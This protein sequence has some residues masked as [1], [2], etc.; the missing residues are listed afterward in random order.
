M[1]G[2]RRPGRRMLPGRRRGS[3]IPQPWHDERAGGNR[4]TGRTE[5]P[6]TGLTATS[7]PSCSALGAGSPG[8]RGRTIGSSTHS[9]DG[10]RAEGGSRDGR[11][12]GWRGVPPGSD[13]VGV[14]EFVDA[15]PR[16]RRS[17]AE[18][19][20]LAI[21]LGVMLA[22]NAVLLRPLDG[23]AALMERVRP[24]T[25][26]APRRARHADVAN[27]HPH[28]QRHAR[29]ARYRMRPQ[30][31]CAPRRPQISPRR[32]R[33][34]IANI[35]SVPHRRPPRLGQPPPRDRIADPR[36]HRRAVPRRGH[37][38]RVFRIWVSDLISA[39][40]VGVQGGVHR[41]ARRT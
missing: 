16:R 35:T 11:W 25:G 12:A 13:A 33:V 26:G 22:V 31:P 1:T 24:A 21:G 7:R 37:R 19:A 41:W 20:V 5:S 4:R 6:T 8:S 28:V 15:T 30:Q 23:L 10:C 39:R 27:L 18:L 38:H 14:P 32:P 2:C 29:P 17:C 3:P 36:P 40:N 9:G 34:V